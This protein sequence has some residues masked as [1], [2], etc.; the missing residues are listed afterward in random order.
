MNNAQSISD[1]SPFALTAINKEISSQFLGYYLTSTANIYV[2]N[3]HAQ[4]DPDLLSQHI[5]EIAQ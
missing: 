1:V 3:T 2:E 5:D 4:T